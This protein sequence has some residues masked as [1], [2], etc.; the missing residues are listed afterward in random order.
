MESNSSSENNSPT[1][2]LLVDDDPRNLD[3]LE[4]VLDSPEYQLV[5]ALSAEEALHALISQEFAVII[6][7]IRMPA[8]SGIELAHLIKQRK[9]TQ[10]IPIIFL[11]AYSQ[12]DEQMLQGYGAGA[13]DYMCKPCQPA[14]LRSKVAVF[15]DLYR[16][17]CAL[18]AEIRE[19]LQAEQRI[20][21]L[22]AQLRRRVEDL[23]AA[24]NELEA[25]T[26]TISHDLRAPLR[27]VSGFSSLLSKVTEG[28][29]D[30]PAS[31]YISLISGAVKHMG[32]LIDDLLAFS[33][34]GR[35]DLHPAA[36]DLR[37]L[38]DQ[39]ILGLQPALEG[40]AVQWKVSSLPEVEGDAA[41]LKQVLTNLLENAIKFTRP[42]PQAKIEVSC[43]L[44]ADEHV[45]RV[46]DNG[47]GFDPCYSHK[48]FK[49]FQRLHHASEFEGTGIGLASVHR[50]IHR[51]GGRTWA[52]S[53]LGQGTSVYFTL[54]RRGQPDP[55]NSSP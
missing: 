30:P 52:D 48:L 29:L 24:N 19:R 41:M 51:H 39:V 31:E 22:N 20:N 46:R 37:R 42:C 6:M 15:V 28:K 33:R 34:V 27:Q 17:S 12:E 7:D 14:I 54:P 1:G 8:M 47:V 10:H 35:I 21:E 9:K 23:A 38:V 50:I 36:I 45:I 16:K 49:V 55:A 3:V 44:D 53:S 18:E 43:T 40:R 5:R 32:Q 4:I 26:Y 25:F 11:T 2:I 13:V